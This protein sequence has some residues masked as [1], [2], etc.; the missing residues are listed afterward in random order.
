MTLILLLSLVQ[1]ANGANQLASVKLAS[2]LAST[3]ASIATKREKIT[4]LESTI[5]ENAPQ[6]SEARENGRPRSDTMDETKEET[7]L[8]AEVDKLSNQ[9]ELKELQS[10]AAVQQKQLNEAKEREAIETRKQQE[11]IAERQRRHEQEDKK[12]EQEK[13]IAEAKGRQR[14]T[15][16][17]NAIAKATRQAKRDFE[18]YMRGLTS[19][20]DLNNVTKG[21]E[22][23]IQKTKIGQ[24]VLDTEKHLVGQVI[25]LSRRVKT[26]SSRAIKE[27]VKDKFFRIKWIAYTY[28]PKKWNDKNNSMTTVYAWKD[29]WKYI[30]QEQVL[31]LCLEGYRA[32]HFKNAK[33]NGSG[34]DAEAGFKLEDYKRNRHTECSPAK[35]VVQPRGSIS[36]ASSTATASNGRGA[37]DP[38]L[39]RRL[40]SRENRPIHR[41]LREIRRAQA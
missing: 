27:V 11:A 28:S 37:E 20:S 10:K 35:P 34:S 9:M 41:L 7:K 3:K 36:E 4:T 5:Q 21:T 38:K 19:F 33:L 40:A 1:W 39:R 17:R 30:T 25:G 16:E 15:R 24:Y 8:Q 13:I 23:R 22:E 18:A 6:Q 12:R 32:D 14:A 2:D 31:E 26:G 29:S